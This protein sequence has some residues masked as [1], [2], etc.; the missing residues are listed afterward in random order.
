MTGAAHAKYLDLIMRYPI[1][2]IYLVG[3]LSLTVSTALAENQEVNG[4]HAG[5]GVVEVKKNNQHT[6]HPDAQWFPDAGLGL[7]I[8]W[9]EAS[10]RC[11]ETSW[12]M[13]AGAHLAWANPPRTIKDDP[14]EFA[15]IIREQ[16]YNL[17]GKPPQITP[18][19]YW[20]L[21]KDFNPTNFHPEVWLK[22]AKEAGFTYAVLTTKH[23]NGFALWPSAYGGF[24]TQDT[25][26]NGRDLVKEYVTAC[27]AAGL[28]V[29]LY[30]SGPDWHFDRD[31]MN[32][33][34]SKTAK[35][36]AGKLP[37]LGPDHEARP[38]QHTTEEITTHQQ[39]VA[40][41]VRGQITE[42]LTHYGKIDLIWFDGVPACPQ[43]G[44]IMPIERIRQLQPGIVINPR[45]HGHGD[46]IT[47][48]GTLPDNIH[49]KADE[50]GELCSCWAYSWSYTKRPFRP[51][52]E[53]LT[54]LVRCRA[55][56]INNLL[57]IGP[58]ATGDFPPEAYENIKK[59][60]GW[61]KINSEAIYGTRALQGEETASVPASSKGEVRYLYLV[62]GKK[63]E[64]KPPIEKVSITGLPDNY[65]AR[66][67][68]NEQ[69][70][71]VTTNSDTISVAVPGD[72]P[73]GS[74]RVVKLFPQDK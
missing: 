38:L 49:L 74:V 61:M 50:W 6:Q 64:N 11:L 63:G 16:D 57:D 60:S 29:G 69:S 23:H 46:Y 59:L 40:E 66:L 2:L 70:L 34:Y 58:M 21:A 31:Y 43:Q 4:Q 27:R 14:A 15:R 51:L 67:L 62:P 32:F 47:P 73:G 10:V 25:P 71:L 44:G 12:P 56:G 54:D 35:K 42:L 5:I 52:N 7:F 36:Y 19:G 39:A 9:D 22:K 24:N 1:C 37:E 68:G 26:M 13:I 55:A 30:F 17:E 28:K 8:H 45:F 3:C 48:E 20:A 33:M 53:V 18:N 72:V 41:M 65:Q